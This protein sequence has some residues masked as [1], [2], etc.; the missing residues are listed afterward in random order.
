MFLSIVEDQGA[1]F[2]AMPL[3]SWPHVGSDFP[4]GIQYAPNRVHR[5]DTCRR[6]P[7]RCPELARVQR[8]RSILCGRLSKRSAVETTTYQAAADRSVEAHVDP[9]H[10][11]DVVLTV[12]GR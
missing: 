12:D 2:F 11:D 4:M 7:R 6:R 10:Q 9:V 3:A 1:M 5:G 8:S